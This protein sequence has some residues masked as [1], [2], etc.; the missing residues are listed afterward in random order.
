MSREA[1]IRILLGPQRP[2]R[3]LSEAVFNARLPEGPFFYPPDQL[4]DAVQRDL[5]AELIR[6]AAFN[7]LREEVPHALAVE[8]DLWEEAPKKTR[9]RATVHVDHASQM[10]IVIGAGGER[11]RS[12]TREAITALRE[13]IDT[14]V[15]LKLHV[16]AT[17][18]WRENSRFLKSLG[19]EE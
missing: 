3:N 5:G 13:Q 6:E 19:L 9:I 1:H 18:N 14:R 2:K 10:P 4:T 17:P 8:I 15:D 12:I 7:H 11:L 16:K